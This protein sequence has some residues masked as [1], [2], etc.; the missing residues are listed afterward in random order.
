[1]KK[2]AVVLILLCAQFCTP[3]WA[4]S[5]VVQRIQI[6]GLNHITPATVESY[7][8]IKKGDTL[9]AGKT[10]S[11]LQE[12]YR[13]GFFEHITLAEKNST[14][15]IRVVERPTIGQL[16]IT[17]N[18]VI[19]T[20]KL[21]AVMRSLDIAEGRVYNPSI[22]QK[23]K[24]SLINQYYQLGRYNARVEVNVST[25]PRNRVMVKIN[26]SEGLVAKIRRISIMGNHAFDESTLIK[27]LTLTTSGLLTFFTQTDR[28]SEFRLEESL[29]KL[30]SFYLD[31]GYVHFEVKSAQAEVTPDRKSVYVNIVV[32]EGAL[33]RIHT[34]RLE[35]RLIYPES[36]YRKY[37][38]IKPGEVFSRQKV[39]D[40]Q[41]E[42]ARFLGQK[43]YLFTQIV[44][45][46]EINENTKEVTLVFD[47][48]PG[49]RTYVRHITFSDNTRTNDIVLRR[50]IQQ[51]EAAPASTVKL[52]DSKHRLS[53]LPYLKDIEMSLNPVEDQDDQV[54]VNYKVKEEN[55][56]QA[57]F[58]VGYSQAYGIILGAGINQKNFLGT[59]NTL[60]LNINTSKYEQFYG[61]EYTDPYY[62]EDGISRSF[63]ASISR[64]NPGKISDLNSGYATNQYD[65]GVLYGIP[66]SQEIGALNR[67]YAGLNY[68]N[69]RIHLNHDNPGKVSNQ[70]NS[71][72]TDHGSHFQ[73]LDLKLGYSRDSRDRAIFPTSGGLQTL[74]LDAYAPLSSRS[75]SF[76]TVNYHGKWY[77]PL[78]DQFILLTRANLGYGNG[79]HGIQDFPFFKNFYAGGIDSVRG[80]QAFTLGPRDS[81]DQAF[82]GNMLLDASIA[83][84]FPN[85]IS[86]SVRTSVFADAGNVYTSLNNR[87]FGG[88]STTTGPIRYAIGIEADWITPFGPIQLSLAK[89]FTRRGDKSE[90]FQFALGA[91][92]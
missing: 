74:F 42:I 38:T 15:I 61:I 63:N 90:P 88:A 46:P 16:K 89:P 40:T 45:K 60:G 1:M 48:N 30:R 76:Y 20:D 4:R 55:S 3:L 62:T 8:P 57:S 26:I 18:S 73:E 39:M 70:V 80:F 43:G 34:Y 79:L 53:L 51:L 86:D 27:Q 35:G 84:I 2:F 14:L 17:G 65:L 32:D 33:Y 24:Q 82:G 58:K 28:Y 77:Q 31:H 91:N 49:K 85:Y 81:N 13:T 54:D 9:T 50:E 29:E 41:K 12:L 22:L 19:P 21:T 87:Q 72:V 83:L 59:G 37:I 69:I 67:I 11:I 6:E 7:L 10:S 75:L 92:F 23:I 5:F 71:F 44:I 78:I 52:E 68:Q 36:D 66:I 64:V 25:M 56:S 47:I